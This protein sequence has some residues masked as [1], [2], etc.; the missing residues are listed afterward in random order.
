MLTAN[1]AHVQ[2]KLGS[3]FGSKIAFVSITVDPER[4]T[5]EVLEAIRA[6]FDANLAGWAFLTGDPPL[7]A[8]VARQ[9]GV[10][11]AKDSGG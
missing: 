11:A 10:F 2:D 9:Y 3:A 1:M 5:P 8:I 4:D 7:S 6:N